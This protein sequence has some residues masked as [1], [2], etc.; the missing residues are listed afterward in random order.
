MGTV[1]VFSQKARL[2]TFLSSYGHCWPVEVDDPEMRGVVYLDPQQI[3]QPWMLSRLKDVDA[4]T[5]PI[6]VVAECVGEFSIYLTCFEW[7]L[8]AGHIAS[9]PQASDAYHAHDPTRATNP[10]WRHRRT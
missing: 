7:C 9:H 10:D 8:Y 6:P 2:D 4:N 5:P 3:T 1:C